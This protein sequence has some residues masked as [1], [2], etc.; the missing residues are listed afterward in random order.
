[1]TTDIS[2]RKE[3]AT[4]EFNAWDAY[5]SQRKAD[6]YNKKTEDEVMDEDFRDGSDH[7]DH[8]IKP[9]DLAK[10]REFFDRFKVSKRLT[11]FCLLLSVID[12]YS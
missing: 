5:L 10:V 1:M 8:F 2:A 4:T 6:C 3:M 12:L 9:H 7:F 11:L